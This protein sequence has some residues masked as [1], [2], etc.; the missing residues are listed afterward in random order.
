MRSAKVGA[1][2]A[3]AALVEHDGDRAL[4]GM[5]LA[6][7]IDSSIMRLPA[8]RA[9]LSRISMISMSRKPM[10]RPA[11]CGALAVALRELPFGTLLQPADGGDAR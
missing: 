1:V 10:L 5:T 2:E 11:C 6:S 4:S 3:F 7:A 8:S 9:R